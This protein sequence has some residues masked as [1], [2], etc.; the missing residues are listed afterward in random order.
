MS[1][2]GSLRLAA[3]GLLFSCTIAP[4]RAQCIQLATS[5][6]P[7]SL[8]P[9]CTGVPRLGNQFS[10]PCPGCMVAELSF[11]IVGTCPATPW[12]S[13]FPPTTCVGG[14]CRVAVTPFQVVAPAFFSARVPFDQS[15][16]GARFCLQCGCFKPAQGCLT[17]STALQIVI[18]R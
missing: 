6:C 2:S 3:L 16:V 8:A 4:L 17:I 11:L 1:S 5:G 12:V 7:V 15:L 18:Q 13:L 9:T 10:V 14:P